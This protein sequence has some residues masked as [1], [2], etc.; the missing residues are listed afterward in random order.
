MSILSFSSLKKALNEQQLKNHGLGRNKEKNPYASWN[1][2]TAAQLDM[3][4]MKGMHAHEF[5][6]QQKSLLKAALQLPVLNVEVGNL[7]PQEEDLGFSSGESSH[8]ARGG[9]HGD[10]GKEDY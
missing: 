2:T 9:D 1:N 8:S 10:F 4:P 3:S 6:Q 7:L 5:Y